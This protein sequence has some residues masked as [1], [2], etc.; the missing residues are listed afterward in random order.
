MTHLQELRQFSIFLRMPSCAQIVTDT[1]LSTCYLKILIGR[2]DVAT[3]DTDTQYKGT[4]SLM[5]LKCLVLVICTYEVLS[6]SFSSSTSLS[7]SEYPNHCSSAQNHLNC[8]N[9]SKS[10]VGITT[11][12][13]KRR[14]IL[15]YCLLCI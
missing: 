14:E 11:L 7:S 13:C 12:L 15:V 9:A 1:H 4:Y 3:T 10:K 2:Y 8:W 6:F 5:L